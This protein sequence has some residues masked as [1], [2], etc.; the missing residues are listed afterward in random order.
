MR[1]E[2]NT[3]LIILNVQS[4]LLVNASTKALPSAI[5]N[6]LKH[7]QFQHILGTCFI[8][9]AGSP[10]VTQRDWK[11]CMRE[12]EHVVVPSIQSACE[13]I[14]YLPAYTC[15]T[16][17]MESYLESYHI[18]HLYLCGIDTDGSV[19]KSAFD[20]FERGYH[21]SVFWDCCASSGGSIKH[22]AGLCVL[23]RLLGNENLL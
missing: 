1:D 20:A 8:N 7:Q 16:P 15:F 12:E 21:V 23:K 3:C 10:F 9:E 14:F 2:N 11:G 17:A 22:A 18:G 5:A 6:I 19:L 13:Q 4:G